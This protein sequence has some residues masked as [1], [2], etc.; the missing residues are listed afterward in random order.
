MGGRAWTWSEQAQSQLPPYFLPEQPDLNW[1][2]PQL[3]REVLDTLRFWLDR[4][5][6][7]FRLDVFNCYVKDAQRRSNPWRTDV[8]GRFAR[9]L[10]ALW[11]QEHQYDRDQPELADVLGQMREVVDEYDGVLL[12]ETLDERFQYQ[13]AAQ[14]VGTDRLHLAFNF[15]LLHSAWNA[16]SLDHAIRSGVTNWVLKAGRRGCC[17]TMTLFDKRPGGEGNIARLE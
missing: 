12:G 17:P 3:V 5:V 14:W 11:S 16:R 7:G 10:L 2:N 13:N 4:G 8:W 6:N 1:R 9:G 15:Q